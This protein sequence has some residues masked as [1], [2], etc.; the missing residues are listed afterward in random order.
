MALVLKTKCGKT[1]AGSNPALSSKKGGV[2]MR[3]FENH[4]LKAGDIIDTDFGRGVVLEVYQRRGSGY[5]IR[6]LTN[7]GLTIWFNHYTE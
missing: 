7:K 3:I 5:L 2:I 1:H 4:N 6:F